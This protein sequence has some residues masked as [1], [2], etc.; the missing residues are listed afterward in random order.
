MS[1]AWQRD[2]PVGA[3]IALDGWPRPVGM[4]LNHPKIRELSL[5]VRELA[6]EHIVAQPFALPGSVIR[7]LHRQLWQR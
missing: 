7:I 6:L 5:P 2:R 3:A 4:E 1:E